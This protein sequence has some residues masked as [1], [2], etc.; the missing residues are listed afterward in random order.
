MQT[1]FNAALH[2]LWVT[3][4][5]WCTNPQQAMTIG[6]LRTLRMEYPDIHIQVL[7][8]D[9]AEH[10]EPRFLIE[11]VL[12]LEDAKDWQ[13]RGLLWTQEPE[14]YLSG[15]KVIVPRL[16]PDVE[17]NNRLNSNRRPILADLDPS[18]DTLSFENDGR[19]TFFKHHE[20]RFV[21]LN[22][23]E[24]ES[25]IKVQAQYSLAKALR[26]GQSGFHHLIQGKDVATGEVVVTLSQ[27][28]M[29]SLRV[30]S[31]RVVKIE[32]EKNA[33]PVL[34]S[35]VAEL[36]A[37]SMLSDVAPGSSIL[38]FEPP[39][40]CIHALSKRAEA[41]GIAI[42]F[43]S[44]RA[45]PSSGI[46]WILL[47]EKETLRSLRQ[48]LPQDINLLYDL[49][50]DQSPASLSQRLARRIPAGCVIRHRDYLFQDITTQNKSAVGAEKAYQA[51]VEA[52][53]RAKEM[54]PSDDG[55]SIIK[56]SDIVL[57]GNAA[58]DIDTLIDWE[59]EQ[60]IPSRIR[61]METDPIFVSD[62]TYLLVGLAGDLGRS[63]ARFM[64]E[65]GARHVVLSSRSPK[66]DQR[67]IDDITALGGNVMV[68][69]M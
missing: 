46:R 60:I 66:I 7:D 31:S 2:V 53:A 40:L 45:K 35:I 6:L 48:K 49:S 44:T 68:L 58:L 42:S 5:A 41:A 20:E 51:L 27:S 32:G 24:G 22:A 63:I 29:S 65:R 55:V 61:S 28:N 56:G 17:K 33:S 43:A 34:P 47:H 59:S 50:S 16:K 14:L 10:V 37:S 4:D 11:T 39:T 19:E 62:K 57:L 3:E 52:V 23:T 26:I 67:W 30:P 8:V 54:P 38:V 64:V 9:K 69:P 36:V 25:S 12:R 18:K 15:G 13:E 1:I 21:P